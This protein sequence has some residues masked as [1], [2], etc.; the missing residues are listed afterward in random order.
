MG[1]VETREKVR[2][3]VVIPSVGVCWGSGVKG[4]DYQVSKDPVTLDQELPIVYEHEAH[5]IWC[6]FL[7]IS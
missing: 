5:W 7:K 6:R 1:G 2:K 4:K 3:V